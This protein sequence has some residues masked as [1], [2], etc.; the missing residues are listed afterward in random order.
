MPWSG[1]P[2]GKAGGAGGSEQSLDL[3]TDETISAA[4]G[5]ATGVINELKLTTSTGRSIQGGIDG[6]VVHRRFDIPPLPGAEETSLTGLS[7]EAI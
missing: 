1:T 4:E 3:A 7:G 6:G 5:Y 2:Q